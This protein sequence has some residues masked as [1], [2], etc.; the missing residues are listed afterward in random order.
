MGR[1]WSRVIWTEGRRLHNDPLPTEGAI[2]RLIGGVAVPKHFVTS[3]ISLIALSMFG[4]VIVPAQNVPRQPG[5]VYDFDRPEEKPALAP[6]H[7]IS[8]VWE[9]AKTAR[10]CYTGEGR[11]VDGLM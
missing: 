11:A 4:V 7:D 3:M 10:G 5:A 1:S 9:P 2:Q 8:G 6:K